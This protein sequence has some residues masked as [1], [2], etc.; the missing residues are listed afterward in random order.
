[1]IVSMLFPQITEIVHLDVQPIN[2]AIVLFTLLLNFNTM[3]RYYQTYRFSRFPLQ[4]SI[5]YTAGWFMLSQIIMVTGEIWRFSWWIYHYLLLASMIV[6][7]IG[8]IKQYATQGTFIS[9]MRALFTNDPFE[10]IT[11][12]ISPS[13]K[14]LVIATE[15]KDKYTVGHTFRVTMYAL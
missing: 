4:L 1:M 5:V 2:G 11:N 14:T 8:L 6:M 7:L 9:A 3:F 12:S 10:R 13:V 15:K